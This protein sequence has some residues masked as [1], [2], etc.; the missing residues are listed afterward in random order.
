LAK[1]AAKALLDAIVGAIRH[2]FVAHT[3][4]DLANEE[5]EVTTNFRLFADHTWST[6]LLIGL[7]T[8]YLYHSGVI[9]HTENTPIGPAS[10]IL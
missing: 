10:R 4:D 1:D 5:M 7:T 2:I 6:C 9:I 8:C 3:V